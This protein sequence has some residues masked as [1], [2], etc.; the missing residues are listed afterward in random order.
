MHIGLAKTG[1]TTIQKSLAQKQSDLSAIGVFCPMAG[2]LQP[3][4]VGHHLLA[5]SVLYPNKYDRAVWEHLH[6][7]LQQDTASYDY[8]LLSSEDFSRLSLEN[9]STIRQ[10]LNGFD[11]SIIVYLRNQRDYMISLYKQL[12]KTGNY[13]HDFRK[14]LLDFSNRYDYF[15]LIERW[16]SVFG[17]ENI[18]IKFYDEVKRSPNFTGDF[19]SSFLPK[20]D[21]DFKNRYT[22]NVSVSDNSAKALLFINRLESIY[23]R[24]SLAIGTSR[25]RWNL[26]KRTKLGGIIGRLGGLILSSPLYVSDDVAFLRARILD[27]NERLFASYIDVSKRSFLEF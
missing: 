23:P 17:A 13:H 24:L 3:E 4:M 8:I 27:S 25:I 2:R 9:V 16:S 20:T 19:L 11:V 7:E 14:F 22:N 1:T 21:M 15:A 10:Y 6:L 5:W 26:R 18:I 12:V